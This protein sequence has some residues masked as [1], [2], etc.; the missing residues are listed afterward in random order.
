MSNYLDI[1]FPWFNKGIKTVV[2]SGEISLRQFINATINP[3]PDMKKAFLEIQKAAEEGNMEL[4]DQLKQDNLFFTT[5]SVKLKYRN[6]ASIEEFNPFAI[7]EYD[8]IEY[9]SELR[10]Y[11][12]EKKKSCIFAFNSPSNRGCK[13]IFLIEKPTSVESYKEL[14]FGIAAE[15]DVFKCLDISNSRPVL[16]LFNSWDEGARFREDAVPST[17]KGYKENTFIPFDGSL[18]VKGAHTEGEKED[19][20]KLISH[21]INRIEDNGHNQVISTSFL[22]GGLTTHYGIEEVEIWGLIEEKIRDNNY[23]SKGVQG[24]IKTAQTM[25]NKGLLN[26]TPM[27][28][29]ND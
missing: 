23:L 25:F 3:K 22:G 9:A 2:P 16:P 10:D 11:I 29:D 6:Y 20:I 17:L 4:K 8:K 26:P 13:F 28:N 1:T 21:L 24:Y 12:F 14:Y 18:E 15:L 27:Q 5:P 7:L 19:C